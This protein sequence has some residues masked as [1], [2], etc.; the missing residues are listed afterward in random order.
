MNIPALLMISVALLKQRFT[1]FPLM[2]SASMCSREGHIANLTVP[3][4]TQ[5]TG[6]DMPRNVSSVESSTTL[7]PGAN[8]LSFITYEVMMVT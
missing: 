7:P 4:H 3:L 5:M 2:H 6:D 1:A 8:H